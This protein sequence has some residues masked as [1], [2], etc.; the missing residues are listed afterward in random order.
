[1]V[2]HESQHDPILPSRAHKQGSIGTECYLFLQSRLTSHE[3]P[4]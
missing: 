1:M 2:N 4:K 3:S